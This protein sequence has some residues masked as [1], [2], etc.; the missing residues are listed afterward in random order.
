M[1]LVGDI[2]ESTGFWFRATMKDGREFEVMLAHKPIYGQ[3]RAIPAEN[4]TLA[5]KLVEPEPLPLDR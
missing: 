1:G 2:R 5:S 4:F 3:V